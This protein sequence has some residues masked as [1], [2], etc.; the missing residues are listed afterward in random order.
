ML[1]GHGADVSGMQLED[2]RLNTTVMRSA[3]G[4]TFALGFFTLLLL[5]AA[6]DALCTQRSPPSCGHILAF[7]QAPDRAAQALPR[8]PTPRPTFTAVLLVGSA[9]PV[10][11]GVAWL[12]P[13]VCSAPDMEGGPHAQCV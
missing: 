6:V 2:P 11:D 10:A 9:M 8:R 1:G 4:S 5:S 7:S 13:H 3:E 12:Q